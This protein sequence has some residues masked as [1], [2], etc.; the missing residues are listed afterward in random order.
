[1]NL[2]V[3]ILAAGQGTRM[4]SRL[5]K[6]LQPLAGRPLL[7][8]VMDMA[9]GLTAARLHVVYGHGGDQV[10]ARFPDRQV[11][12]VEQ[13][14]Q[15]G[16]GHAVEQAMPGI[17]DDA[18]VLVL[19]GDVPLVRPETADS[20]IEAATRGVALLTVR[21]D[22][23][24]GY[25]RIVRDR[26]GRVT[27]IVEQ[28]DADEDERSIDEVNTGLM[29]APADRLRD[30]LSRLD[31]ANAQGE[32]YLTDIVALAVAD[33]VPVEAVQAGDAEEVMGVNDK[34]QLA[35]AEAAVRRRRVEEL[36]RQGAT[37][38]DPGRIDV[39]GQ[40]TCGQDVFLDVGVVLEG[41]VRLDDRAHVGPYCV[42][43]DSHVGEDAVI[44][45]HSVVEGAGVGAACSVGPFARLRPGAQLE[46][47]AKVGN[48]VE[49]KNS[50][51]GEGSKANHLSY[52]GDTTV[53][54]DTNIGAGTITCNYDGANKHRTVIG[55]RVFIGS[56]VE[57][58]A[59]VEVEEGATIGAGS[60]ISKRAPAETLTVAR[61]RQ[62]SIRGWKR[63]TK[64]KT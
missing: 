57:L 44:H 39:R 51:L 37:V 40:V 59:P 19:Y 25:G 38:A 10:P 2:D 36:M 15:L 48:F 35:E 32:F 20:L 34:V 60:T 5:P 42:V 49:V 62:V 46:T 6:V 7:A 27:S 33:G 28:K 21:M 16:T 1:M 61:S 41:E 24:T 31:D 45:P 22:D 53:G 12:W 54:R 55:D 18:S 13:P 3:V 30:W 56:G 9:A 11:S 50:R 4:R 29:A 43:R 17:A 23:P 63:P 14:E 47:G 52:V 58:V 8:H 64:K 26:D